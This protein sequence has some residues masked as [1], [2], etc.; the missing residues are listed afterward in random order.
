MFSNLQQNHLQ[1]LLHQQK[2]QQIVVP[3]SAT[4]SQDPMQ[5]PGGIDSLLNNTAPPNVTLTR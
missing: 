5:I 3:S 1:R 4:A 2:Q